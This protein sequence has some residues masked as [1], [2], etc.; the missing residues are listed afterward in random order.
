MG[1]WSC[2]TL[3]A[4]QAFPEVLGALEVGC[5]TQLGGSE[6][7]EGVP[8][9]R[10]G[11]ALQGACPGKGRLDLNKAPAQERPGSFL[12]RFCPLRPSVGREGAFAFPVSQGKGSTLEQTCRKPGRTSP[13]VDT[14]WGWAELELARAQG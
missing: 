12:L 13:E 2:R 5:L 8:T 6:R 1:G 3:A 11:P 10:G 9:G 7:E 4:G 14:W